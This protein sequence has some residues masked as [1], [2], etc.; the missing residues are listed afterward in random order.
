MIFNLKIELDRSPLLKDNKDSIRALLLETPIEE[1]IEELKENYRIALASITKASPE[2]LSGIALLQLYN[3]HLARLRLGMK[4]GQLPE[5]ED[6]WPSLMQNE[7]S[8]SANCKQ[9]IEK[10]S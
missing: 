10:E 4:S 2:R 1:S 7:Q 9:Y 8:A 5:E 3:A 6:I